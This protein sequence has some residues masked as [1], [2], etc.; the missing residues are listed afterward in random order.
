MPK[1][2]EAHRIAR[3]DAIMDA[4]Q[5]VFARNGYRGTSIS[6]IITE[7]GLST[8]AIYS[9]FDGKD[10]I[11]R[12]VVERVLTTRTLAITRDPNLPP[13][14]PGEM[15]QDVIEGMRGEPVMQIGPQI[16]AEAAGEPAISEMLAQVFATLRETFRTELVSWAGAHPART[17]GDPAGWAARVAPVLVSAVPGFILQRLVAPNFDDQAYFDGLVDA[18]G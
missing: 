4:A 2:T 14:S 9:Y 5:R 8:G 11:F 17:N 18:L 7:S 6:D 10:A 13:R 1:V 12:A 16:W 3:R 15:L